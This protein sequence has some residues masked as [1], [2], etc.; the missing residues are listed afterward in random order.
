MMKALDVE[1]DDRELFRNKMSTI[2]NLRE[3]KNTI[4]HV[5]L[6]IMAR[7]VP[8][9]IQTMFFKAINKLDFSGISLPSSFL[10]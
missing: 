2:G 7:K 3:G 6:F 5:F 9:E 8:I 1:K 10:I 4:D